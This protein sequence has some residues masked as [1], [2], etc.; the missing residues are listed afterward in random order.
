MF[1]GVHSQLPPEE[2]VR[3][4]TVPGQLDMKV[5]SSD[6][7]DQIF[8]L[9]Q[10][11]LKFTH[12][13]QPPRSLPVAPGLVY[14]QVSREAQLPE[15]QNVQ[16]SLSLAIRLNEQRIVGSIQG[17]RQLSIRVAGQTTVMQFTLFVTRS[18]A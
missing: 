3:L 18:V 4:L 7:V 8:R 9:G 17:R 5:G 10:A 6:R 12:T 11:G 1:I 2:C 13:P 14:F 16:R 15:W